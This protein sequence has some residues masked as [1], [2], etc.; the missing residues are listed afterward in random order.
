MKA[1]EAILDEQSGIITAQV[2]SAIPLDESE[3]QAIAQKLEAISGK[4][5]RIQNKVN[6]DLMGGFTARIGDT[7]ID[8]S[9]KHKLQRLREELRQVSLN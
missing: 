8:G 5:I 2:E 9:V 6:P 1:F 3:K 7:V 4:K